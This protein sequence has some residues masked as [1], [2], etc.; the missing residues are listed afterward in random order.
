MVIN[1]LIAYNHD[2]FALYDA[3]EDKDDLECEYAEIEEDFSNEFFSNRD[4]EEARKEWDKAEK[5]KELVE[6][7]FKTEEFHNLY[8]EHEHEFD[9]YDLVAYPIVEISD[10]EV[11]D[12]DGDFVELTEI[13]EQMT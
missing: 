6:A 11:S 2:F 10:G 4:M 9:G 3:R 13:V 12:P 1:V 7:I 8:K 5:K